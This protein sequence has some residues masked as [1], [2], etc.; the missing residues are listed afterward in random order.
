MNSAHPYPGDP[1]IM[2][3]GTNRAEDIRFVLDETAKWNTNDPMFKGHLDLD[4]VGI[5]GFSFGG[6]TTS[7]ACAQEPR[8][9]AGLSLDGG[10]HFFRYPAFD[11]PFLILSG[12]D[13]QEFMKPRRLSRPV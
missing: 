9:K 3:I 6:G 10:F 2:A 5:F 13:G 1:T 12:G 8:I 4:Q 11:R 7:A